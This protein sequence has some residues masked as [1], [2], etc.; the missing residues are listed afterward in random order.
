MNKKV[1]RRKFIKTS[2]LIGCGI[3]LAGGGIMSGFISVRNRFD[4]I[5]KNGLVYS[6]NGDLPV[7]AD[8]AIKGDKIAAIGEVGESANKIINADKLAVS[9]GFIDIHTH[10]DTNLLICPE[11]DS[12]I[13]QGITTDVGGNCGGSPFPYSDVEF[14]KQKNKLR[15]GYPAWQHVNGF[16]DALEKN[17]ISINYA[18]FTGH[19]DLRSAVVGDNDIPATKEQIE[20]MKNL[21]QHQI[22]CGSIGIS[23]GLEYAPGSYANTRELVELCRVVAKNNALY[24]IH[25]RNEDDNV[26]DA[27]REAIEVARQ[28]GARLEISHLKA[29]NA[30]N[31][32]KAP[33][34]L[35]MIEEAYADGVDIAFDR[36]PYIAFSTGLSTFIP[37]WARQGSTGEILE[38][39]SDKTNFEK[40]SQYAE[41]R[42]K[43]LGGG[44]NVIITSGT[45]DNAKY[46]GKNLIECAEA[47]HRQETDFIR[48][49]LITHNGH[50]DMVC[51]A[52]TEDNVKMFLAHKLGM[53]A[54]DGYV[55]SPTGE[56]SAGKPHPRSY[57]TFPRFFGKYCRDEKITDL[58]TA[59]MKMTKLPASRINLKNRGT[60]QAGYF[61]DIVV[62]DENKIIDKAEFTNPH[63]FASGI[64]HVFVNGAHTINKGKHTGCRNGTVLR[65][66]TT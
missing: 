50:V 17:K 12:R 23:Y 65:H 33:N 52:M 21:L 4:V 1:S 32:Y 47:S 55:Y 60:I 16:F 19:G 26:E 31:W 63:Q 6:G 28:A 34:M 48:D 14:E 9:P 7:V 53:P 49:M 51:F 57:G 25:M 43:R 46:I 29:Q 66:V 39:L 5:I 20:Q 10:T 40:I 45:G 44:Q 38:R 24:A 30:N 35:K 36:Y 13:Y 42:I 22:D 54:S 62:F 37:L 41:S 59:I 15:R 3:G 27:I 58:A 2:A 64:E 56:L 18:S 11:G 61:A 8:I